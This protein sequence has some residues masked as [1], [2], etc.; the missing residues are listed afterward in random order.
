MD[1][2]D[3]A[4]PSPARIPRAGLGI[5]VLALAAYAWLLAAFVGAVAGGSDSSGYMNHARLLAS[6]HVH[7]APRALPTLPQDQA[8]YYLYVPLGFKPAPDGNG[9]VPTYP[10]GFPLFVLAL[11]PLA[12]WRHAGDLAIILHSLAGLVATYLLARALGLGR[13][14]AALA[15]TMLGLSPLYLFMSLQAMS[16]VP[17]LTW[18]TLAILAAF[19]SRK[20]VPWALAAGAALAVDVLL[21][22]ANL[23]AF[24]PVAIALGPGLRR[25]LLVVLAGL[26]GAAFFALHSRAAYGKIATTGYGDNTFAFQLHFIPGTLVHYAVW[27]PVLLSP[28]AVFALGLPFL[29]REPPPLRWILVGWVLPYAAFY[30]SYQNTHESWW[31]L[32]FLLPAAP[33]VVIGAVFVLRSL[34]TRLAPSPQR[35]RAVGAFAA[36]ALLVLANTVVWNRPL[37]PLIIGEEE[38]RYGTISSWLNQHLPGDA[39]CLAMQDTGALFYGTGFTFLRWDE[40]KPTDMG[41]VDDAVRRSGRPLYAVLFPFELANG[42]LNHSLPGRWTPVGEVEGATVLRR[43]AGPATP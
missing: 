42:A 27:L 4:H 2:P 22:P 25:W 23:L 37:H 35:F 6:G 11:E 34:A 16:D 30:C 33:A 12:G 36:A 10:T 43:D 31:Y 26:P 21:R 17:S 14:G 20:S 38:R 28:L 1:F 15:T 9:L 19:H 39:V 24:V 32:R 8:P 13:L 29:R 7:V 41:R 5:A 40:I 3:T 18:T